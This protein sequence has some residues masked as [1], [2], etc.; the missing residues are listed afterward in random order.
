VLELGAGDGIKFRHYPATVGEVVALEPE[1]YLRSKAEE[2]ALAAPVRASS[3]A[4]CRIR[5]GRSR[6]CGAC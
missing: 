2:A 4:P 1:A 3:C 6:S 5:R